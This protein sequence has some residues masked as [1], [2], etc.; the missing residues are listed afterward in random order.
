MESRPSRQALDQPMSVYE[1]HLGSWRRAPDGKS[2]DQGR[3]LTYR[4]LADQ[5]VPYVKQMGYTHIELMPV[6]EH[7]FDGSGDTRSRAS[8]P[9]LRGTGPPMLSGILS[10]RPMP[11]ALA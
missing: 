9:R 8:L 5:V 1:V 3:W 6:S 11:P 4:E 2:K 10:R 7:P